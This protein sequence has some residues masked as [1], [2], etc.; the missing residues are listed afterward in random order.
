[1]TDKLIITTEQYCQLTED[2]AALIYHSNWKFDIILCIA[3]GGFRPGDILSRIFNKP[4]AI[5]AARSYREGGGTLQGHLQIAP[6]ISI[7]DGSI[8]GNVLLV[9]DLVDTGVTF[10]KIVT[11]LPKKYSEITAIRTAVIW[12]KKTSQ[13]T[14]DFVSKALDNDPWIQQP[15][16]RYDHMNIDEIIQARI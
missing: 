2:L 3:R 5:L 11:M 13:F 16:E 8:H 15:F 10:Q 9:D 1:M 14:P 12:T 4:L 7:P 6:A